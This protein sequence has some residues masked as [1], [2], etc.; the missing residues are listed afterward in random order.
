[1]S[2][3]EIGRQGIEKREN[4]LGKIQ[5]NFEERI[6]ELKGTRRNEIEKQEVKVTNNEEEINRI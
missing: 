2:S 3:K 5:N 6:I 4:L 1:M